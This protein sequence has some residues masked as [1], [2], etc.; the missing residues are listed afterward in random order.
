MTVSPQVA[1]LVQRRAS[2]REAH[3]L[4]YARLWHAEGWDTSGTS[5]RARTSQRKAVQGFYGALAVA[6]LGGNGTGKSEAMG[7]LVVACMLGRD[8]PDVRAWL[9]GNHLQPEM[10]PPYPGR[11]LASALT[12]D[13]S[14][15]VVRTKVAKYLPRD[16]SVRWRNQYGDGVAEA[17]IPDLRTGGNPNGATIVFKSNDQG[18]RAYQGDEYD[19]VTF[20]EEHDKDVVTESM[21]RL[22]RRPWKEGYAGH[23]MT[24]LK[25]LTYVYD[26][27]VESPKDGYRAVWMHGADNPHA[28][29]DFRRRQQAGLSDAAK[30]AREFGEFVAGEGRVYSMFSRTA[31]LIRPVEI[32][33]TWQRWR[34]IDFGVT[35]PFCCLWFALDPADRV[36]HVYRCLYR[37]GY[38]TEENGHEIVRLSEGERFAFDVADPESLD[39]RKTLADK[40]DIVTSKANKAV[41]EGISDV[42][43]VL[44]PDADGKVHLV[45]HDTP[46]MRPLLREIEGYRYPD[47]SSRKDTSE[48]PLKKNDHAMDALRYGVRFHKLHE[49]Y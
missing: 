48:N 42:I 3:P 35:N 14:R 25:G 28:D 6:V 15:R 1:S 34:S 16:G 31:H 2:H 29:Q 45:F 26:E 7:Q 30:R 22:G 5:P 33:V 47:A 18:Q 39:G 49:G 21:M 37:P 11:V 41:T 20:D 38:S 36:Y 44:M 9:K 24:P 19:I 10:I 23:F 4:A 8:H 12:S 43:S 46:D 32:P 17:W 40:C 13:D 27:F